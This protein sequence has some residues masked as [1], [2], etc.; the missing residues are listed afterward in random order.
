MRPALGGLRRQ[1]DPDGTGGAF[2]P[3]PLAVIN[4]GYGTPDALFPLYFYVV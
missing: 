2:N 1:M 4:F 3:V